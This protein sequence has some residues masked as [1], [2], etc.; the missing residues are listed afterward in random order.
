MFD[1]ILP[2]NVLSY[3]FNNQIYLTNSV[4]EKK[5][6]TYDIGIKLLFY[7]FIFFK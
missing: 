5:K 6:K 3:K 1:N 2:I 4:L 7:N